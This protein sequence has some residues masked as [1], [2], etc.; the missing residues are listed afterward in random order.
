MH[1]ESPLIA[2]VE[3]DLKLAGLLVGILESA[4]CRVVSFA[5]AYDVIARVKSRPPDLFLID[6]VL[7]GKSGLELCREI[8][9]SPV[10]YR[11]PVIFHTGRAVESDRLAGLELADDYIVKPCNGREIIAR[12]KSVL[13]RFRRYEVSQLLR[14]G[15]LEIWPR[16]MVVLLSGKPVETTTSEFRLLYHFLQ[17]PMR[18]FTRE[19]LLE[20]LWDERADVS[21]RSVDACVKR[22][23]KKIEPL[24][25]SP[26]YL[27]TVRGAGYRLVLPLRSNGTDG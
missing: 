16:G 2:L 18:V 25:T 26:R 17:H 14:R 20:T 7:P 6:L 1:D 8:R 12:V 5:T 27:Q 22:L 24:K 21:P 10:L 23:R 13:R 15:E 4:N 19:E 3:D 11:V 9:S